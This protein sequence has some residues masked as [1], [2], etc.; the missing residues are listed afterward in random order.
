MTNELTFVRKVCTKFLMVSSCGAADIRTADSPSLT[1]VAFDVAA[2]RRRSASWFKNVT[3]FGRCVNGNVQAAEPVA[4]KEKTAHKHLK[5][6]SQHGE[7]QQQD[8]KH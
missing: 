3:T 6:E 5:L 1:R 4:Q 8:S 7:F 2:W